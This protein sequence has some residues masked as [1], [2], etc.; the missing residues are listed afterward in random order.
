M[1][2]ALSFTSFSRIRIA[3]LRLSFLLKAFGLH[4]IDDLLMSNVTSLKNPETG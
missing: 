2:H 1:L 4:D 3:S